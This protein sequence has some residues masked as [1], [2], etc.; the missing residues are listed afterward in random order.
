MLRHYKA[1]GQAFIDEGR[2]FFQELVETIPLLPGRLIDGIK[3]FAKDKKEKAVEYWLEGYQVR[4]TVIVEIGKFKVRYIVES[5]ETSQN[6]EFEYFLLKVHTN[7]PGNLR[8]K[9]KHNEILRKV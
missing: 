7:D 8:L 4:D 6:G 9:L 5:I 2:S 1:E 3:Q